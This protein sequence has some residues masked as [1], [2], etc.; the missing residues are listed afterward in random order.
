MAW[1]YDRKRQKTNKIARINKISNWLYDIELA[2]T[3]KH[4]GLKG[5]VTVNLMT[6]PYAG[7]AIN[8]FKEEKRLEYLEK[9]VTKAKSDPA[10]ANKKKYMLFNTNTLKLDMVDYSTLVKAVDNMH[11][12][13][14]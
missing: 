9:A 11:K 1:F 12:N 6:D 7:K 13:Y 3:C 8:A 10:T 4:C 2:E 14:K 5:S